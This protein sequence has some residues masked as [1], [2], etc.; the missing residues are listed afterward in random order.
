MVGTTSAFSGFA[1]RGNVSVNGT[2][3]AIVAVG[4]AG[5]IN[6]YL[7]TDGTNVAVRSATG[8]G[9]LTLGAAGNDYATISAAGNFGIGGTPNAYPN[10]TALTLNNA[11]GTIF[12]QN[13]AGVRTSTIAVDGTAI[14]FGGLTALPLIFWTNSAE[15]AR[16]TSAAQSEFLVGTT[17]A[18]YSSSGRGLVEING[19]AEALIAFKKG[20]T[21]QAYIQSD[22]SGAFFINNLTNTALTFSTNGSGRLVIANDGRI[23]GANLHNNAGAVTGTTN[24][25]IA[26]GTYTPTLTNTAN[27]SASTAN[28]TCW[29]RV[30]NVVTVAGI[31]LIDPV[32]A[33]TLTQINISLPIAS[34]FSTGFEAGGSC[35][36]NATGPMASIIGADI[37]NHNVSLSYQNDTDTANRSWAFVF[38]YVIV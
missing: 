25:Y 29:M 5:A 34:N 17:S 4:T 33:S 31:V 16:I 7:F 9:L 6:G 13:I 19:S 23:Y 30:G 22:S 2:S 8:S 37:V 20:G 18:T 35:G 36:R 32:N 11:T 24:Q 38:Q 28:L 27:V 26:S 14:I 15:K 3:A 10:R 1:G 21:A 12:D